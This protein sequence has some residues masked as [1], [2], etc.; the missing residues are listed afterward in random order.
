MSSKDDEKT[1][2]LVGKLIEVLHGEYSD[3]RDLAMVQLAHLGEKAVPYICSYL[4]KEA[5]LENDLIKYHKLFTKW[6]MGPQLLGPVDPNTSYTKAERESIK[7]HEIM[8]G[9]A[10]SFKKKWGC[11]PREDGETDKKDSEQRRYGVEGA[12]EALSIIGDPKA[13]PVLQKLPIY[14]YEIRT[15]VETLSEGKVPLFKKARE[16]IE[17]IH[18]GV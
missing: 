16:T 11:H 7:A 12:L 3:T 10:D 18:K 2:R 9:F 14:N 15:E 4:E 17:K 5:E 13:I 8:S 6:N 1:R